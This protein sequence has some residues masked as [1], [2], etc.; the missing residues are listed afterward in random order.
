MKLLKEILGEQKEIKKLLQVIASNKK[1]SVLIDR[2]KLGNVNVSG[3]VDGELSEASLRSIADKL[4][5]KQ[6][7]Q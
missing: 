2:N 3:V 4:S 7:K 6:C 5:C 1:Q